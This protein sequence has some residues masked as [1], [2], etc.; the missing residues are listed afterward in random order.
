MVEN[1][2][3]PTEK[4][5]VGA[6]VLSAIFPGVG[7][8]YLGNV[9]K[10][11]AYVLI[12]ISLLVLLIHSRGSDP[13]V[14]SLLLAAFYVFQ[15]FDSYND[16]KKVEPAPAT[17]EKSSEQQE[18]LSLFASITVLVMGIVF[19]LAQL[20]IVKIRDIAKFWPLILIALGARY[21][22]LYS[23]GNKEKNNQPDNDANGGN[24]E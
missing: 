23:L 14:F 15:I 1:K 20:D 11:I 7:F 18:N 6:A 3:I 24:Y 2:Q 5:P 16:A 13:I 21:L 8:F 19:Q 17:G 10:G 22:Y 12:F 9:V 4:N